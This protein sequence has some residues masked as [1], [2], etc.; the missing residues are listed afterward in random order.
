MPSTQNPAPIKEYVNICVHMFVYACLIPLEAPGSSDA[1]N[2]E[3]QRIYNNMYIHICVYTF[4][5]VR[6]IQREAE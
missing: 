3:T 5:H 4:V 2:T 6:V 1:I